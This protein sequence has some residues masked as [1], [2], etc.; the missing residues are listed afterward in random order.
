VLLY[1][2]TIRRDG[3]TFVVLF[4][5]I[6]HAHTNG[7][8]RQDAL[9]HAPDAL[10]AGIAMLMEKNLEIP[11]PGKARGKNPVLVGLPSV[12]SS[13]KVELYTALR[14]CGV[15]K[16]ELAR[17]MGIHKQQVERLMDIGHASRIEQLEAAFAAL[18]MRL[19]VDIR[20]AA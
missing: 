13:A 2:A 19:I 5:D 3:D 14:A 17:R 6:A 8:S 11:S 4:P 12:V 10:Q 15:R 7:K 16:A 18:N 20:S 9:A 1:P